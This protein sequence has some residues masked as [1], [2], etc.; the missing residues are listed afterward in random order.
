MERYS[1]YNTE[2]T[3]V[4][5]IDGLEML[6]AEAERIEKLFDLIAMLAETFNTEEEQAELLRQLDFLGDSLSGKLEATIKQ[7]DEPLKDKAVAIT[8][9]PSTV[10][11]PT[12]AY[13]YLDP[14]KLIEWLVPDPE[15]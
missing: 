9:A 15:E 1:E 13:F 11:I 7:L 8:T 14:S 12:E 5:L 10:T 2:E 4:L 3:K 6:K